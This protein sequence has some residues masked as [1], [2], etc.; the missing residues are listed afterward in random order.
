[1][2]SGGE[3]VT[4]K[5]G[6][7]EACLDRVPV[8]FSDGVAVRS[9]DVH[10]MYPLDGGTPLILHNGCESGDERTPAIVFPA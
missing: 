3:G 5:M 1:M 4:V 7:C 8:T 2:P 6:V 9:E 10:T